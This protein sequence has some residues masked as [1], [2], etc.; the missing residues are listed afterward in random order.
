MTLDDTHGCPGAFMPLRNHAAPICYSCSRYGRTTPQML[1]PPAK[2]DGQQ[3][4]CSER[5]SAGVALT[6]EQHAAMV[7]SVERGGSGE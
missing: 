6:A 3:W 1:T 5:R 4:G 2:F 7:Q